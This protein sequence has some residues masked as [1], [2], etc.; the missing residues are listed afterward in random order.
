MGKGV[1]SQDKARETLLITRKTSRRL[2]EFWKA[3]CP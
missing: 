1:V 3:S 2:F